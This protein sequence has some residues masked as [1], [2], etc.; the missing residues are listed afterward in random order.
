[1][2]PSTPEWR[3]KVLVLSRV[4]V[5]DRGSD[6]LLGIRRYTFDTRHQEYLL[7]S[8]AR[9]AAFLEAESG[10]RLRAKIDVEVDSE[11]A[12]LDTAMLSKP[13]ALAAWFRAYIEPRVNGGAFEPEDR[14]YRGP[15]DSILCVHSGMIEDCA[16]FD[17]LGMPASPISLY[18]R[19]LGSGPYGL[20]FA[21]LDAWHEHLLRAM[22][23]SG[24]DVGSERA[25][26]AS[27]LPEE[28]RAGF[29]PPCNLSLLFG[30]ANFGNVW[31]RQETGTT[32]LVDHA[33]RVGPMAWSE[34]KRRSVWA[35]PTL[36]RDLNAQLGGAEAKIQDR[37]GLIEFPG[38]GDA[39]QRTLEFGKEAWTVFE[40]GG[41]R[42][43][44]ADAQFADA[45]AGGF[46]KE[47]ELS[48]I[49]RI[50]VSRGSVVVFDAANLRLGGSEAASLAAG[51]MA[52]A[53]AYPIRPGWNGSEIDYGADTI[54]R[55]VTFG[56]YA[57][58]AA[59]DPERGDV[60]E[61]KMGLFP[62][63]GGIWLL[64]SPGGDVLFDAAKTP[65]LS[66]WVRAEK[67]EPLELRLL[68]DGVN[69]N[70]AAWGLFGALRPPSETRAQAAIPLKVG[71]D[72]AWRQVVIDLRKSPSAGAAMPV[73]GICLVSSRHSGLLDVAQ[74]AFEPA[75][76]VDGLA[77]S[78]Q[79]PG[80][81][82]PAADPSALN[83]S[84]LSA[85]PM[86]RALC[87]AT[88]PDQP[89][90]ASL[91]T[92]LK[93]LKDSNDRVRLNA[94]ATYRRISS[95]EAEQPLIDALRSLDHRVSEQAAL[96]LAHQA[97]E[98]AW[99]AIRKTAEIGPFDFCREF[100]ARALEEK[101]DP[102]TLG[103]LTV[104]FT[105]K[106]WRAR[107]AGAS[108]IASIQTPAAE[109]SLLIFLYELDPAVRL[110]AIRSANPKSEEVCKRLL[111]HAVN[112]SS[113]AVRAAS[114]I[115]LLRSENAGHRREGGKGVRD[116]SVAVRLILL[117]HFRNSPSEDARGALRIAV[118]DASPTV[119]GAALRAFA[120]H[121]GTVSFDEVQNTASDPDPRVRTAFEELARAKGLRPP[122]KLRIVR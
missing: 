105:A 57:C 108:A 54:A 49:C 118:T 99:A 79:P 3:I 112:D 48:A 38:S 23:N 35:L 6:G 115:A 103:S 42:F 10:G 72:G 14:V 120:V 36:D 98:S 29:Q 82:T 11:W 119:R 61:I 30:E 34:V 71:S 16:Q 21:L 101:K 104:L 7:D 95:A 45:A 91:A 40:S 9:F 77:V 60:L 84:P 37:G 89:D 43:L 2:S 24:F 96:A 20:A 28:A 85:V 90:A 70:G 53:G 87:A 88:I 86:E 58:N 4:D 47:G 110:A 100:A 68:G 39:A 106:S 113:D 55:S 65:F 67:P 50:D 83:P 62:R 19:G 78:A 46:R 121:P 18:V 13:G 32:A 80:A 109:R 102:K 81:E 66:L 64:G 12:R 69:W 33:R 93:L 51:T 52:G 76:Y 31:N 8:L 41:K 44:A 63:R 122:S 107:A 26:R 94:C 15:Y 92:L 114:H 1:M 74:P 27:A 59:R 5:L 73:L 17:V 56:T 117:E 97:T 111:W 25:L 116:D 75:V 22:T